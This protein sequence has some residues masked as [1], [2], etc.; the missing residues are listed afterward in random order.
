M[1]QAIKERRAAYRYP[2]RLSVEYRIFGRSH[3][4]AAGSAEIVNMSSHG[5][6]INTKQGVNKG[7]LIELSIVWRVYPDQPPGAD[8][9]V[10][11]RVTRSGPEGSAIRILRYGF[12]PRH[13][14]PADAVP[15]ESI[16]AQ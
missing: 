7:Q 8:L 2:L 15:A 5:L 12:H 6:L 11:G 13:D 16:S 10:L 9:L 1:Q 3:A 14:A 4:I